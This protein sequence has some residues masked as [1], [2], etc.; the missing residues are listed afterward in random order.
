MTVDRTDVSK[1][2]DTMS[3]DGWTVHTINR[4]AGAS[5]VDILFERAR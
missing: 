5:I 1:T 3:E 4:N 2:L